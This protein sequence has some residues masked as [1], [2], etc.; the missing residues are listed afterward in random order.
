M[1]WYKTPSHQTRL[2]GGPRILN[3]IMPQLHQQPRKQQPLLIGARRITLR[4]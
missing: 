3:L 2:S 1:F 4:R